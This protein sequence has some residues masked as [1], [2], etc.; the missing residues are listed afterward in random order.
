VRHLVETVLAVEM[1][2]VQI[3]TFFQGLVSRPE[4]ASDWL[5]SDS[6]SSASIMNAAVPDVK[7]FT[8]DNSGSNLTQCVIFFHFESAF[9]SL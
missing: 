4:D 7:S 2:S 1:P 8:I 5:H 9:D 3:L 6:G